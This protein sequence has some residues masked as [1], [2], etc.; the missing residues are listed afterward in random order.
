VAARLATRGGRV[1]AAVS[2]AAV[3]LGVGAP[4]A[5]S[6]WGASLSAPGIQIG[7]GQV[8]LSIAY[9]QPWA[10]QGGAT[11]TATVVASGPT[12]KLTIPLGAEQAAY[13]APGDA[14]SSVLAGP[15]Q[16]LPGPR[17]LAVPITVDALAQGDVGMEYRIE[18]DGESAQSLGV[19]G[20]TDIAVVPVDKPEECDGNLVT[21]DGTGAVKI[22]SPTS[23]TALPSDSATAT[24]SDTWCLIAKYRGDR[25]LTNEAVITGVLG[26]ETIEATAAWTAGVRANPDLDSNTEGEPTLQ[27]I[28]THTVLG[29]SVGTGP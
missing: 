5:W 19:F 17:D 25:A 11:P 3:V 9:P 1:V 8:G 2:A 15:D 4:V 16:A 7:Q 21:F 28:V 6:L 10:A 20:W 14:D 22:P 26:G 18:V 29:P 12:T 23:T 27:L 24:S 13:I